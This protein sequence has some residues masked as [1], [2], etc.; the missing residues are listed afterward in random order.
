[1]IPAPFSYARP[2]SLQEASTLLK[3]DGV[4]ILAGGQSLLTELKQRHRRADLVV[5]LADLGLT[6]ITKTGAGVRIDAMVRQATLMSNLKDGPFHLIYETGLAVADPSIRNRGTFVGA[7]MAAEPQGDWAATALALDA[8][9]LISN[10]SRERRLPYS[11]WLASDNRLE[12]G[13][14]AVA[15]EL[16]APPAGAQCGYTK[17]KHA[18]IGWN[19]ASLAYVTA[20]GHSRL[21]VAGAVTRPVRLEALEQHLVTGKGAFDVALRDDLTVLK[22][23]GD[24]YASSDYRRRRLGVLV[25]RVFAQRA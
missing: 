14:L 20:P 4:A 2:N 17:I 6:Q 21:V 11:E 12:P 16:I 3:A 7:L 19:I 15:A 10:G 5:D 1:M 22:C 23:Q 25:Q 13:E 9:L 8:H 18:A 24:P